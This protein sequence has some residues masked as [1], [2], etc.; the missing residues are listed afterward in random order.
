MKDR[1]SIIGAGAFASALAIA[2][3]HLSVLM[4]RQK[5]EVVTHDFA[6]TSSLEELFAW[7]DIVM[8][9]IPAQAMRSVITNCS[10]Y[11]TN[12][13]SL[14]ICSKGVERDSGMLMSEVLKEVLLLSSPECKIIALGGP[15]FAKDMLLCR[16]VWTTIA[17][18]SLE[19]AKNI[20]NK[21][22]DKTI[23]SPK[24]I[25]E[26][27]KDIIGLQIA[28]SMKNVYAI[29][30]GVFASLE[31]NSDNVNVL[32][33]E[34]KI[35]KF[36]LSHYTG[37]SITAS[38]LVC[39]LQEMINIGKAANAEECTF[40]KQCGLGDLIA[41]CTSKNSR[42]YQYGLGII[43]SMFQGAITESCSNE[44]TNMHSDSVL[45]E[46]A[47]SLMG[48]ILMVKKLKTSAPLMANLYELLSG[49]VTI[50]AFVERT[51][52]ILRE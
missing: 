28:G 25:I 20:S 2:I 11:I 8:I 34:Q 36:K 41:T 22:Y 40:L 23:S 4:L 49:E 42:N 33:N 31:N 46:G 30:C 7:S 39:A 1:F 26:I 3:P 43:D 32:N 24:L 44:Q 16:P 47:N 27:S 13:T 9:A 19:I 29:I 45:V 37:D 17:A 50:E 48:I 10:K 18:E 38:I 15:N 5:N 12:R 51:V 52:S 6:T 35:L 21:L 14:I